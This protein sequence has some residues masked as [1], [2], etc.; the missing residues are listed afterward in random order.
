MTYDR[1]PVITGAD[2]GIGKTTAVRL[3]EN[4]F[5]VG[6]THRPDRAGVEAAG[7]RAAVR[8]HDLTAPERAAGTVDEPADDLGG[9]GNNA[10]TTRS[11]HG[12]VPGRTSRPRAA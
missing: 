8:R 5:D 3:A 12:S 4:E 2:S 9:L 7:Q 6:V 10:G 1:V 11:T